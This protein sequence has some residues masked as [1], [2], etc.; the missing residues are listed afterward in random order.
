MDFIHI[1]AQILGCIAV[2]LGFIT[3]QRKTQLEIVIFRFATALVFSL[4][5][6]LISAYTAMALNFLSAVICVFFAVMN[7]KNVESKLGTIINVLLITVAGILAWENI[8]SLFLIAGLAL[9]T[10]SLSFIN[11]Q[12]T[13]RSMLIKSPLCMIYNFKVLSLGG[14]V[15]ECAVFISAIIGLIKNKPKN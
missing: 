13:R 2:I 12:N 15:F 6:F 1:F 9:N 4:H 11:P 5:Y 10:I 3:F 14:V 8:Y 7:K